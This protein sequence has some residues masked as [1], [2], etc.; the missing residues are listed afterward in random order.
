M[1]SPPVKPTTVF[2]QIILGQSPAKVLHD[3]DMCM[4]IDSNNP[5]APVHFLVIPKKNIDNLSFVDEGDQALMGHMM[6]VASQVAKQKGV[7]G[8]YRVVINNDDTTIQ[9]LHIHVL[10]GRRMG[11]PPG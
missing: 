5:L 10:G 11:W 9:H 6:L 7:D 1:A 4:A 8:F 3:D 2:G